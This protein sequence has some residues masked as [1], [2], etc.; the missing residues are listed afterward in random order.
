MF[1]L[2]SPH[3]AEWLSV[4]Q[5]LPFTSPA[6]MDRAFRWTFHVLLCNLFEIGL[7]DV[8]ARSD[9]KQRNDN[10]SRQHLNK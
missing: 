7:D 8:N 4:P 5:L 1:P 9:A 6:S 2:Q 3:N 10:P